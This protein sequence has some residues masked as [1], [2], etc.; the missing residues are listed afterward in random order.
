MRA[1]ITIVVLAAVGFGV[2]HFFIQK[3]ESEA[4]KAYKKFADAKAYGKYHEAYPLLDESAKQTLDKEKGMWDMAG[5]GMRGTILGTSYALGSETVSKDGNEVQLKLVQTVN[6]NP[7]G[8]T[9]AF[10]REVPH[11]QTA[12]MRKSAAGW[13]VAAF[14]DVVE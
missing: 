14:T 4:F 5:A 13:R 10:G 9:S 12:T 8:A 11:R 6:L 2:Y 7:P 1:L 3:K